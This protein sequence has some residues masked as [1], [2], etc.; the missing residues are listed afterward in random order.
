MR[1]TREEALKIIDDPHNWYQLDDIYLD[2]EEIMKILVV[3]CETI[4]RFASERIRDNEEIVKMSVKYHSRSL[5]YASTRLMDNEEIVKIAVGDCGLNLRHASSRLCDNKE[6]AKLA[7]N[8]SENALICV[9][10]RLRN[11]RKFIMKLIN[12]GKVNV[13]QLEKKF[14]NDRGIL[15][16]IV[17]S[18]YAYFNEYRHFNEELWNDYEILYN[19]VKKENSLIHVPEYLHKLPDIKKWLKVQLELKKGNGLPLHLND[20]DI[21]ISFF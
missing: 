2:D 11:D 10:R 12:S 13:Q 7:V 1:Y 5:I 3:K 17:T 18:K 9:S 21:S 6:I 16:R 20:Y 14:L 8:T 19:Y 15:L 4:L